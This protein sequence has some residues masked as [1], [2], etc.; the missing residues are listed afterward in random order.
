MQVGSQQK[1]TSGSGFDTLNCGKAWQG[2]KLSSPENP[3]AVEPVLPPHS[4]LTRSHTRS[5]AWKLPSHCF[6]SVACRFSRQT[7]FDLGPVGNQQRERAQEHEEHARTIHVVKSQTRK[8]IQRTIRL[9]T[10]VSLN[11]L[12]GCT[13]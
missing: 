1:K 7:S 2:Y 5:P 3:I 13:F 12:G 11:L 9:L 10:S 4:L 6:F 8:A